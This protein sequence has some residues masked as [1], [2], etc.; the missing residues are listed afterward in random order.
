[1]FGGAR[2]A[3]F[4]LSGRN[5][6]WWTKYRGGDPEAENFFGGFALPQLQ[7]NRELAAYP[8]SR[9]LWATLHVEF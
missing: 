7:R 9:Q 1:V 8:A 3:R 5:L 4:T 6:H 2:A